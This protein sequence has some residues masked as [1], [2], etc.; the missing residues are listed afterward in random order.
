MC[1]IQI[2]SILKLKRQQSWKLWIIKKMDIVWAEIPTE[3]HPDKC[4]SGY[5]AMGVKKGKGGKMGE[6]AQTWI[7]KIIN[8]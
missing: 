3:L 8:K 7:K 6:R 2:P 4:N 1:S 5:P